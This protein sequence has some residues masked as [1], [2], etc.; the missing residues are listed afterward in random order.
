MPPIMPL[1][2]ENDSETDKLAFINLFS[3]T[4]V[5]AMLTVSGDISIMCALD[6]NRI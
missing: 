3:R 6:G 1:N 2:L 5:E 4:N